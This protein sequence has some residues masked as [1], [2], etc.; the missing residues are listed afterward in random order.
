[1]SDV[2]QRGRTVLFV[3]HDMSAMLRLTEEAILLEEGKIALRAPTALAVETYLSSGLSEIGQRDWDPAAPQ[4]VQARPFRPLRLRVLDDQ[5]DVAGTV[6]SSKPFSVEF[7]YELDQDLRGLRVGIY[8]LTTRGEPV[9]TSFDTDRPSDFE[10]LTARSAGRYRSRCTIPGNLLNAGRFV[11]GVNA[12]VFKVRSY[13]TDEQA[14]SFAVEGISAP[15]SQWAENRRGPL[16][17]E[18]N[19]EV[20]EAIP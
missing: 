19:W 6:P 20:A 16:R 9:F 17:P 5:G 11:L 12:S 1:M 13:F 18:L 10:R 3:S 8:L 7:E 4:V 15:G 14:L 2:A